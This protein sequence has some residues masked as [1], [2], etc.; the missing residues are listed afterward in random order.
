[1]KTEKLSIVKAHLGKL[2]SIILMVAVS[3]RSFAVAKEKYRK[4]L[5]KL[6]PNYSFFNQIYSAAP[7][8]PDRIHYSIGFQHHRDEPD[9]DEV[10]LPEGSSDIAF[11][12]I[13]SLKLFRASIYSVIV[14]FSQEIETLLEWA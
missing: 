12:K 1:M 9:P 13:P 4:R 10:L 14:H 6:R 5:P 3:Q 8:D 7:G 2:M 11:G